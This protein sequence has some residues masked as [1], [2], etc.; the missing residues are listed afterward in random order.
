[1]SSKTCPKRLELQSLNSFAVLQENISKKEKRNMKKPKNDGPKKT[2]KIRLYPNVAQIVLLYKTFGCCRKLYNTFLSL[3]QQK[4]PVP[5]ESVF[6]SEFPYMKEVDS[7]ALQQSRLRLQTAYDNFFKSLKGQRKG[8]K[9]GPPKFKSKRNEFQSYKSINVNENIQINFESR[10][11]KLP[12]IGW[13]KFRDNRIF[14][15][16]INSVTVSRDPAHRF[17]ASIL[18]DKSVPQNKACPEKVLGF[19]MSLQHLIVD[20]SGNKTD[21]PRYFRK[22]EDKL[23][24]EQRKLSRKQKASHRYQ[25]QK[26]KVARVHARI[27]D[28]RRDFLQKLSTQITNEYNAVCVE[29]LNMKAMA[30]SLTLGKSVNDCGWGEFSRMLEYKALWKGKHFIK[31]DKWF[32]SSKLCSV[33]GFKN[34]ALTLAD[35]VWTCPGCGTVQDRDC[36]AAVNVRDEGIRILNHN[37]NSSTV[38]TAGIHAQGDCVRPVHL[39]NSASGA[40]LCTG[41]GR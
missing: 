36:N 19:D 1:M 39:Q 33:C 24:W 2:F 35:R 37:L 10:Q 28:S 41:N 21:Y 12:K 4:Q 13:V 40:M 18:I 31:I 22:N 8:S 38:G 9:I 5:T 32:P 17:H 16:R 7:I 30:G 27:A 6:K 29:S 11:I 34:V 14:S 3:K 26:I 15:A 23:A 25:S 20:S